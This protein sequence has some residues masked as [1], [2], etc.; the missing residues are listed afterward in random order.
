M[1]LV[2]PEKLLLGQRLSVTLWIT[3]IVVSGKLSAA[4]SS[5]RLGRD[6]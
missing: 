3:F 6:T 2:G 4:A 1:Q 5:H